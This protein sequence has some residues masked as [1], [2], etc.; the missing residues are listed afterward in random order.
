MASFEPPDWLILDVDEALAPI[1]DDAT[2]AEVVER[3][4]TKYLSAALR[5]SSGAAR[6][7]AWSALFHFLTARPAPRK[8][9]QVDEGTAAGL[10]ERLN[11]ALP[12]LRADG[13]QA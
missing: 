12:A 4:L 11:V 1:A 9:W 8:P 2:R 7:R 3:V 10:I 6:E 5:A 13:P